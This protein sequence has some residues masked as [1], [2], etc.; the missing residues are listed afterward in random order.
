[1]PRYM[2]SVSATSNATPATEDTFIELTAGASA[3]LRL[4]SFSISVE[5]ASSDDTFSWRLVRK[6]AAGTGG[7]GFTPVRRDTA[8]R[9]SAATCNVKNGT[10][11]FSVGTATDVC[12][13]GS[14]NGR[15]GYEWIPRK[16]DEEWAVN[17]AGIIG[18]EIACSAASKIVRV[19]I[20]YED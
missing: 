5:S 13:Q 16:A 20:G 4:Q 18:I 12:D 11:G 19:D 6:S 8:S 7:T 3:A 2:A 14:F 9:T 15:G 10:T 17:G 1:M